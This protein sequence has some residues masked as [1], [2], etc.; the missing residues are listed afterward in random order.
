M[1][2]G[3]GIKLWPVSR[4]GSPLVPNRRFHGANSS[5]ASVFFIL[6]DQNGL[7][8]FSFWSKINQPFVCNAY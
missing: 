3:G 7:L 2:V 6:F 5:N 8:L 4:L 1:S